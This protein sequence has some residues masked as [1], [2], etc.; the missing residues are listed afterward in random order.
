VETMSLQQVGLHHRKNK[1]PN[2]FS[3]VTH[4]W[5]QKRLDYACQKVV[6]CKVMIR[7]PH[8]AICAV[9]VAML[10]AYRIGSG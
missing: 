3:A 8:S 5:D 9:A 10:P 1:R 6:R 2:D 7:V 4:R